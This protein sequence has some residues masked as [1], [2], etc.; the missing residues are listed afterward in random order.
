[1]LE[2]TTCIRVF[3]YLYGLYS[4]DGIEQKRQ[5]VFNI[6]IRNTNTCLPLCRLL[7]VALL[8]HK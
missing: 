7:H 4:D 1:M 8:L 3:S 6:I 2:G 5:T